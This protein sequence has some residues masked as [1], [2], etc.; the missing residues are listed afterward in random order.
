MGLREVLSWLKNQ[1]FGTIL[2]EVDAQVITAA[3]V[4]NA[5]DMT[6]FGLLIEDCKDLMNDASVRSLVWVN[7]CFSFTVWSIMPESICS[8][9]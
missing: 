9:F 2:L 5:E 7:R 3:V 4:W 6:E 1:Q 8:S